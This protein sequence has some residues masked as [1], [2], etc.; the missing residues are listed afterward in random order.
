MVN[1]M[2]RTE[3]SMINALTG[4]GGTSVKMIFRFIIQTI[5]VYC[6]G[7]EYVGLKGFLQNVVGFLNITELGLGVAVV[8][9]LYK[10]IADG[11]K[12]H[13]AAIMNLYKKLYIYIGMAVL[14]IAVCLSPFLHIF[15]KNINQF[16]NFWLIYALYVTDT[17]LTY[18]FFSYR[19]A[20]LQA[21]QKQYIYNLINLCVEFATTIS[22][23]ILLYV[24]HSFVAFLIVSSLCKIGGNL[25]LKICT[26]RLYPFLLFKSFPEVPKKIIQSIK[27]NVKAIVIYNGGYKINLMLDTVLISYFLDIVTVGKY[28]NYV[29]IFG[30]FTSLLS[31]FFGAFTASIGNLFIEESPDK[32]EFIFCCLRIINF[33]IGSVIGIVT[34]VCLGDF[35]TLWIGKSY[36][37]DGYTHYFLIFNFFTSIL[38]FEVLQFRNA[39][40]LFDKGKYRPLVGAFL[41]AGLSICLAPKFGVIGITMGTLISTYLTFWWFDSWLIYKYG[42]HKSVFVYYRNYITDFIYFATIG[43]GLVYFCNIATHNISWILL[44]FK[45]LIAVMVALLAIILRYYRTE[46][47]DYVI[48]HIRAIWKKKFH[49]F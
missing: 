26:D 3:N 27:V 46:E 29:L 18:W 42:F 32:N 8:Y 22:Q 30:A 37:F 23:V 14:I 34:A 40:G 38:D 4:V 2:S 47:F 36:C 16:P 49:L 11:D 13:I 41:N 9:S 19:N 7:S 43:A 15:I 39:Y 25:Y 45:G 33:A 31:V 24:T 20:I 17:L 12:P 6:L 35:I 21:D 48:K 28:T 10:V 5:F 1:E 44:I